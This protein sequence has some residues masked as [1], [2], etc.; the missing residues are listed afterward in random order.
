[1]SLILFTFA[2]F[3]VTCFDINI[4][5]LTFLSLQ[6]S[7]YI[8]FYPSFYFWSICVLMFKIHSFYRTYKWV[9]FLTHSEN[10]CLLIELLLHINLMYF[11]FL[12][13]FIFLVFSN[14]LFLLS[15]S[16]G[17]TKYFLNKPF[18]ENDVRFRKKNLKII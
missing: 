8:F 13:L 4:S 3:L 18:F 16:F 15:L 17:L 12:L 10:L 1:M 14:L 5:I 9:L 11:I 7:W 2:I 6:A